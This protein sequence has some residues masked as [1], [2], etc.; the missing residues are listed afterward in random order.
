MKTIVINRTNLG[1]LTLD[2][3]CPIKREILVPIEEQGPEH[4]TLFDDDTLFYT[5]FH[6][7]KSSIRLFGPV[8]RNLEPYLRNSQYFLHGAGERICIPSENINIDSTSLITTVDIHHSM[9]QPSHLEIIS[10]DLGSYKVAIPEHDLTYLKNTNVLM[11]LFK[12][13]YPEWIVDWAHFH[14]KYH[15]ATALLLFANNPTQTTI[16][17][18]CALLEKNTDYEVVYIIDWCFKYGPQGKGWTRDLDLFKSRRQDSG[19]CQRGSFNY[20]LHY[21][22]KDAKA[23]INADI[24]ELLVTKNHQ[25]I[26]TMLQNTATGYIRYDGKWVVEG[27]DVKEEPALE[28]RRHV[29][30]YHERFDEKCPT[31]WALRISELKDTHT[32]RAHNIRGIKN[33]VKYKG[34]A[35]YYHFL[36]INGLWKRKDPVAFG[37]YTGL[38]PNAELQE[39]YRIVN[40]DDV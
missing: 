11:T 24:D 10:E 16:S 39:A 15:G 13:D 8:L 35:V 21:I 31:K 2:Q 9:D 19:F 18:L 30:F 29:Q 20:A 3:S 33:A 25:S 5:M 32:I 37:N 40:W 34:H 17:S 1:T 4:K 26:F 7:S 36:R 6:A 38:K 28:G 12:Y 23:V 14:N 27:N 22:L